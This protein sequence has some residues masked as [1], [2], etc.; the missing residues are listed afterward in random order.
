[1]KKYLIPFAFFLAACAGSKEITYDTSTGNLLDFS[2]HIQSSFLKQH[3]E[4]IAHDSLEGRDTAS[5]GLKVAANYLAEFY[6][7]LNFTPKGDDGSWFQ[8]FELNATVTDS[9]VY[10]TFKIEE[11][12]TTTINHT[13]ITQFTSGDYFNSFGGSSSASGNII[14]AG[15][16]VNDD[17][18]GVYHLGDN[19]YNNSWIL[20]FDDIP[21]VVDGDTLIHPS[22]NG[23]LR[24]GNILRNTNANGI[25]LISDFS[26]Q[27][28]E[29]KASLEAKVATNPSGFSLPYLQTGR[30]SAGLPQGVHY[31]SPALAAEI[32]ELSG[33]DELKSLY[34]SLIENIREFRAAETAFYLDYTPYSGPGTVQTDNVIA[35]LEG[36]DSEMKHETLVLLAHYDHIGIG[37]PDASGDMI[38]NGADDNGS[39][40]VALMAIAHALSEA[41][42]AGFKPKRSILF[43]HV[44]AEEVGLLGSRYYSDHPVIPIEN[45]IASFN[46]DM[47]GRS[48]PENIQTGDTDYVYLIGG[49][50][51]SSRLDSL[52][53]VANENSVNMRLD[54]KYNDLTD[55]N[56]FYRRSDHWNFGRLGVPFVFF[57]T[58]VHEDYHRPSDT[59]DKI[60]F[61]K[62][63]RVVQLIYASTI[64]VANYDGHPEVDNQEF[65]D[66]TNRL[67]R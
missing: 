5:R 51:I 34:D 54:R 18:R 67:A 10:T 6:T 41:K 49:E 37:R 57:F 52:I 59:V 33:T 12:D 53:V 44:S 61:D 21:H 1:M 15:F 27:A 19:E 3:L 29:E 4:V 31:I 22:L 24:L 28:F 38:Y 13:H 64:K 50:I 40:T 16:G 55:P 9:V 14:F 11:A 23:N 25:L 46:A 48:D 8:N 62:Y 65:I 36:A 39:G 42:Q 30:R 58:G 43:L 26:Q 2:N 45:T 7:S 17:N 47:I 35:Y 66:I 20:I 63:T 56:Q 32:L 60:D